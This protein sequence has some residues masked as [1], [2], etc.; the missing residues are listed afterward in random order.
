MVLPVKTLLESN[1]ACIKQWNVWLPQ[2][3]NEIS[4]IGIPQF[5]ADRDPGVN[6][7]EGRGV[8]GGNGEFDGAS[9]CK[10]REENEPENQVQREWQ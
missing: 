1:V 7:R 6:S 9:R 5:P 2:C 10:E 8:G 4:R 3:Q